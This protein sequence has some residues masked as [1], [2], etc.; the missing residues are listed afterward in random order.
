MYESQP[1]IA[2]FLRNLTGGGAERVML[3]LAC[4]FAQKGVKVDLILAK[5][6]G[7]YLDQ[8]PE[9]IQLVDFD[10]S[11]LYGKFKLPTGFQSLKSLPKLVNYLREKKPKVLLSALHFPNEVAILAKKLA[12]V[13]TRIVVSEHTNLSVEAKLV[14]QISS[15]LAPFTAKLLYPFADGIVAVSQGAADN[16]AHLTGIPQQKIQVIYNPVITPD[17]RAKMTESVEHPWFAPG[18]PPVIIGAGRFVAQKDFATLIRAFAKVRQ[19]RPARLMM[20]GSGREAENLKALVKELDIEADVFW[21]G[22]VN[23]PFAYMKQAGVFVMSSVWEGFGNV[24]VEAMAVGTPVVSTNCPSG[25]E[26]ILALG[27]Y[28]ELV[29]VGDSEAMA[30][31]ILKVL[32]G[33]IQSVDSDWL[34]QFTWETVTQK[35]MDFLGITTDPKVNEYRQ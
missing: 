1:D 29:P 9:E 7:K 8:V 26:E 20:L 5:A 18:E 19:I 30:E 23:N 35:Y 24:V 16:L 13:S 34:Q 2:I 22:F 25:P 28:G 10:H 32:S 33:D 31:A 21:V 11:N 12:R 4:G 14:E 15:R 17:L 6:N 27:K 3:N